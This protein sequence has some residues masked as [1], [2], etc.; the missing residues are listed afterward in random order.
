MDTGT[1]VS[2]T[3]S[4]IEITTALFAPPVSSAT[5]IW[6][7]Q[8]IEMA[9]QVSYDTTHRKEINTEHPFIPL[10]LCILILSS[11]SFLLRCD[12]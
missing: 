3:A 1:R 4:T 7:L 8:L 9:D 10:H 5:D 2:V 11:C 6:P 12:V